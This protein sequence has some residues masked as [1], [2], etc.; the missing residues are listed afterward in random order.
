MQNEHLAMPVCGDE[1][2]VVKDGTLEA[3]NTRDSI[4]VGPCFGLHRFTEG[5]EDSELKT[6]GA[7]TLYLT[8]YTAFDRTIQIRNKRDEEGF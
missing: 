7:A 1:V 5:K 6:A 4:T 2:L 8:D 3:Y